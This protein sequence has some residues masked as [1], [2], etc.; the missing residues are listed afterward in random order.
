MEC[1]ICSE[2]FTGVLRKK[3]VCPV[4]TCNQE[5]CKK[6]VERWLVERT[7]ITCPCCNTVWS[8]KFS[9]EN[10]GKSFMEKYK[11]VQK[12]ILFT[13]EKTYLEETQN[14]VDIEKELENQYSEL[15]KYNTLYDK[16]SKMRIVDMKKDKYLK[17][18]NMFE[19]YKKKVE[20]IRYFKDMK[21]NISDNIR[22]MKKA[23]EVGDISC[24]EGQ[25][26]KRKIDM[27]KPVCPCPVNECRGYIKSFTYKCGM[28]EVKICK[29]CNIILKTED[30]E[31][32]CKEEDKLTVATIIKESKP[33]PKCGTR[34]QKSEG[35]SQMYCTQ[36]KTAF[37]YRTGKIET[38]RIHN[39]HYY[40]ELRR[41]HGD[42]IPREPGDNPGCDNDLEDIN[43][44]DNRD[45]LYAF[46][47]PKSTL[48]E[49]VKTQAKRITEMYTSA[50]SFYL[51]MHRKYYHILDHIGAF[52]V[53]DEITFKTNFTQRFRY[54]KNETTDDNFK[55]HI[56]KK[57]KEAM[58]KKEVHA[59]ID[60]YVKTIFILLKNLYP[61]LDEINRNYRDMTLRHWVKL[62]NNK[63]K[64]INEINEI[65]ISAEKK[66][67]TNLNEICKT[68]D[69]KPIF[70]HILMV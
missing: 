11:K 17:E 46:T 23:L 4:D 48:P 26:I 51:D 27:N 33:C 2:K 43:F 7:N 34:I 3:I 65:I 21:L 58:Y 49:N 70:K 18:T 12:E 37:D 61:H 44:I 52:Q 42:N 40:E 54:L 41:L 28:C 31:H 5:I 32:I 24:L 36:C 30:G 57:F 25:N 69:Y 62:F 55:I 50:I 14:F 59:E 56:Y 53:E 39:P 35:C 67:V 29:D 45:M 38:G 63:I 19:V 9:L 20:I 68:Y 15:G 64:V 13:K 47:M 16:Y 6:C 66:V 60:S 22:N 1:S 10:I 8:Y